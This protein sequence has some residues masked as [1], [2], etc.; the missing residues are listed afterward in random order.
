MDSGL[1]GA[2]S[3][4][5]PCSHGEG[6]SMLGHNTG[7]LLWMVGEGFYQHH[8]KLILQYN[9]I[10]YLPNLSPLLYIRQVNEQIGLFYP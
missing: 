4:P 5:G 9:F 1:A 2:F 7:E 3:L 6:L 8:S 10:K